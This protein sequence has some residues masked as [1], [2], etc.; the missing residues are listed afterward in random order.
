VLLAA[1]Y[2]SLNTA[3]AGRNTAG[4]QPQPAGLQ[5]G[6]AAQLDP[7]LAG[8]SGVNSNPKPSRPLQQQQ[9]VAA[10]TADL[11]QVLQA[12]LAVPIATPLS[13]LARGYK[14]VDPG[15]LRNWHLLARK[16]G[17]PGANVTIVAFG[18]SLTAGYLKYQ[19]AW[20]NSMD[21]S[22]VEQLVTWFEVRLTGWRTEVLARG[23]RERTCAV[24]AYQIRFDACVEYMR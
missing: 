18:G 21:G 5:Q 13:V 22:W 15:A 19:E 20:K 6:N 14:G 8:G 24:I 10:P 1:H 2:T 3:A 11:Q 17:T 7:P 12:M 9:Q 23:A 16:L 4:G